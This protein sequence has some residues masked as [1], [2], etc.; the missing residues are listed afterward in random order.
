[1][2]INKASKVLILSMGIGYIQPLLITAKTFTYNTHKQNISQAKDTTVVMRDVTVTGN[3]KQDLQMRTSV[4]SVNIDR[5]LLAHKLCWQ[6]YAVAQ[7]RPRG[8]GYEHWVGSVEACHSW[9]GLQSYGCGN[10]CQPTVVSMQR[11]S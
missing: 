3:R 4:N 10:E 1:M 6:P 5:K 11:T 9:F 8:Q 2:T 7:R